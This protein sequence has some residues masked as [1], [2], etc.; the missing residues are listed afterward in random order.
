M[1]FAHKGLPVEEFKK[2]DSVYSATISS[3][4]GKL[5]SENTPTAN[6]VTGMFAVKPTKFESAGKEVT[7]DSLCNGKVTDATPTEAIRT[8]MLVDLEPIIESYDPSWVASTRNWVGAH[9]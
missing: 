4:T 5:A 9:A 6:R 8:G 2:P 3:I 1:D 7:V